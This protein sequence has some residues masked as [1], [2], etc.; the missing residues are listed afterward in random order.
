MDTL[1]KAEYKMMLDRLAGRAHR[2]GNFARLGAPTVILASATLQVVKTAMVICGAA[3]AEE[4]MRW[5]AHRLRDGEGLCRYCGRA[6]DDVTAPMCA[7]C[8]EEI[9]QDDLDL[10]PDNAS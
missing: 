5:I 2:L 9:E 8:R 3:V 10:E 6:K 7:P 1:P 4:F